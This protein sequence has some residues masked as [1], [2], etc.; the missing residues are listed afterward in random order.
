M[1]KAT[2][3]LIIATFVVGCDFRPS[4]GN[5]AQPEPTG[6]EDVL[7]YLASAGSYRLIGKEPDSDKTFLGKLTMSHQGR[8]L[9]I[10]R[11]VDGVTMEGVGTVEN[12]VLRIRYGSGDSSFEGTYLLQSDPD[13][14]YARITGYLYK[15]EQ[16]TGHPVETKNPGLEVLFPEASMKPTK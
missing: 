4:A 10:L 9:Q 14:Y 7:V 11:T 6:A 15:V 2:A 8:R 16:K 3:F 1:P 12:Q 5:E 13:N